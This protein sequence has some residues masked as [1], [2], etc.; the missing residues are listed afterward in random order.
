MNLATTKDLKRQDLRWLHLAV[1]GPDPR[2]PRGAAPKRARV[3]EFPQALQMQAFQEDCKKAIATHRKRTSGCA[4][5][6]RKDH[7]NPLAGFVALTVRGRAIHLRNT[8][9]ALEVWVAKEGDAGRQTIEWIIAE[10]KK[11][12]QKVVAGAVCGASKEAPPEEPPDAQ[13][14]EPE[15]QLRKTILEKM[16]KSPLCDAIW[17]IPSR[18]SVRCKVKG[19]G[20]RVH[21]IRVKNFAQLQ[22]HL[23][24]GGALSLMR[25]RYEEVQ[26]KLEHILS[27]SAATP[28]EDHP[29]PHAEGVNSGEDINADDSQSE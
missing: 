26:Q 13:Q 17:W 1:F 8:T 18:G 21:E 22:A 9:K 7:H 24:S 29:Q 27:P 28:P 20:G 12:S 5:K 4:R 25:T 23:A 19:D 3:G 6:H 11:D 14:L 2:M 10:V 16:R 15:E